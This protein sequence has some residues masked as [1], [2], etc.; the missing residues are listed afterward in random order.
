MKKNLIVFAVL[1]LVISITVQAQ[2]SIAKYKGTWEY[3]CN[4]APYGFQTGKIVIEKVGD[5]YKSTTLYEDGSQNVADAVKVK[6]GMLIIETYV[7]GNFIKVELKKKES[8]LT[9]LVYTNEGSLDIVAKK[10]K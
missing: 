9:G 2:E 7:E 4:D 3:T 5:K 6:N 10:K 8:K 1:T